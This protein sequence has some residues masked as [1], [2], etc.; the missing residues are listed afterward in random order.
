MAAV[1]HAVSMG[2]V[3]FD[4]GV[5]IEDTIRKTFE[6]AVSKSGE[7]VGRIVTT[8]IKETLLWTDYRAVFKML[9]EQ[10][11]SEGIKQG[12]AERDMEIAFALLT[13]AKPGDDQV[14]RIQTL[15]DLGVPDAVIDAA[16]K[17][18]TE[19]NA[20]QPSRKRRAKA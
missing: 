2:T 1:K 7:E 13:D 12:K 8:S 3:P 11:K 20:E 16:L 10:G 15:K 9:E 5:E 18:A 17:Q 6:N 14:K 4:T 19:K